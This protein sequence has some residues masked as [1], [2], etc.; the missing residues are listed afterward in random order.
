MMYSTSCCRV[1][2]VYSAWCINSV[3]TGRDLYNADPAQPPTTAGE[4]LDD[5]HDLQIDHD[6]SLMW[7]VPNPRPAS[8]SVS[9]LVHVNR[10]AMLLCYAVNT[11]HIARTLL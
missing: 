6:L 11:V 9:T 7:N 8:S 10:R 5:L 3:F 1:G 2:A 4:E